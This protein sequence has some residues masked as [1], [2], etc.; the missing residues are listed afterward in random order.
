MRKKCKRIVFMLLLTGLSITGFAQISVT[1]SIKDISGEPLPGVNIFVEGNTSIGTVTDIDGNFTINA[2]SQEDVLVFSFVGYLTE[3]IQVNDQ[4]NIDV[5]L[6][7]DLQALDE[8]VVIGYG[9]VKK[10]DLTGSVAVITSD[11]IS[12]MPVGDIGN[13]LVGKTAGVQITSASGSPGRTPTIR[14]RGVGTMNN[15]DPI[16]VID[17][18]VMN[19]EDVSFLNPSDIENISVL[20]D[21]SAAAIYGTK[22]AN[23]VIMI[24]TKGGKK[25]EMRM[26][27][28]GYYGTQKITRFP[29]MMD[30][31][32]YV[33]TANTISGAQPTDAN[34]I[35]PASITNTNWMEEISQVAPIQNHYFNIT[36]GTEA[37]S[38]TGSFGYFDQTGVIKSTRNKKY[39]F[40]I[41]S[42]HEIGKRL[43]IGENVGY[44]NNINLGMTNQNRSQNE[45]SAYGSFWLTA[46]TSAPV[47][48]PY[49]E[50]GDWTFN[51]YSSNSNNPMFDIDRNTGDYINNTLLASAWAELEII[52]NLKFKS[53]YGVRN[54]IMESNLFL[55]A[56]DFAPG[57]RDETSDLYKEYGTTKSWSFENT[58]TYDFSIDKHGINLMAGTSAGHGEYY[59][60]SVTN[61][62]GPAN[63]SEELQYFDYFTTFAGLP[64]QGQATESA[65]YG[66]L[67][68]LNY[69]YDS[70]YLLTAS[71][72]NDYSS[73]FGPKKRSGWF[74]SLAL[75][76]KLSN[77]DFMKGITSID[78]LKLRVGWGRTGN[79]KIP[80]Y[81]Y[82]GLISNDLRYAFL[83]DSGQPVSGASAV[84]PP[85]EEVHWE[86]TTTKNIGIDAGLF[87]NRIQLTAE[88]YERVTSEML[89]N[90]PV[91]E[92]SGIADV[93][94]PY[95]NVADLRNRG[96]EIS[97]TY[98]NKIGDLNYS[99]GGNVSGYKNVILDLGEFGEEQYDGQFSNTF[100]NFTRTYAGYPMAAFYGYKMEGIFQDFDDV[101]NHAFQSVQTRPGDI[102]FK[103]MNNDGI[104]NSQDITYIGSPHPKVYYGANL[105][106]QYKF[107]DLSVAATGQAGNDIM[108][109]YRLWTHDPNSGGRNLHRDLLNAWT[110]ENHS[111]EIPSL[112]SNTTV[113]NLRFSDYYLEKGN[114]LRIQT[115]QLG[116]TLPEKVSNMIKI[117]NLR[118]YGS[119]QNAF[120][121]TKYPDGDP[122]VGSPTQ[123]NNAGLP[124]VN[125]S[126]LVMSTDFGQVPKPRTV[127]VGIDIS[128]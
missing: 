22:G 122:E 128:F 90:A 47:V 67:G 37:S 9:A 15:S 44:T 2:P 98:K 126:Q 51:S 14:V 102:K 55:P 42:T 60:L 35:D 79:D 3:K 38:F 28:S 23:G 118:I 63:E 68:R 71:I 104:V 120:V 1:G 92:I 125:T 48:A 69:N 101:N 33:Q 53:T 11:D 39:S 30:G 27:Y 58:L 88:I 106:I 81:Q 6:I 96:Y 114:F 119:V 95:S 62:D 78:M 8:V 24:T 50:D 109:A 21:A 82:V 91:P 12:K 18:I 5:V 100:T 89:Y 110:E 49:T 83:D 127:L 34:Y 77:E 93:N 26:S 108:V 76:W 17:G 86:T 43:K 29:D 32:E 94:A 72:R 97:L 64:P 117:Q 116:F 107:V 16:Y 124:G 84:H 61:T 112:T 87:N 20:K 113:N 73:N 99:L 57:V 80:P 115:I 105:Y 85:N 66:Y 74:P 121:F 65:N 70:K 40:R 36:G 19:P 7:A 54:N 123:T 13:A 4:T 25:G 111:N 52:K 31:Y 56:N 75:A 103:D 59:N 46:M 45:N 41:N 10:S